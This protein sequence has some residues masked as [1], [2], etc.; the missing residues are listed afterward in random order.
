[1][2]LSLLI[3]DGRDVMRSGL[4]SV[5]SRTEIRVAAFARAQEALHVLDEIRPDVVLLSL[6]VIKQSGWDLF[7][8]IAQRHPRGAIVAWSSDENPIYVARAHALGACSLLTCSATRKE[9]V[10][11]IRLAAAGKPA[12]LDGQLH[13]VNPQD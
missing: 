10:R 11:T 6:G 8:E 3:I 4:R 9:I 7:R 2:P 5:F 13:I 1:M 12:W